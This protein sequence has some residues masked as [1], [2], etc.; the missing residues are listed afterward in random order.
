MTKQY[1]IFM[2]Q[3]TRDIAGKCLNRNNSDP[4]DRS[5]AIKSNGREET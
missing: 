4:G 5:K 1:T 2:S 3:E